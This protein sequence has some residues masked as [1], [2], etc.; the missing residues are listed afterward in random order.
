MAPESS[1]RNC[2]PGSQKSPLPAAVVNPPR[3]S[4]PR[5]QTGD[6]LQP[7]PPDFLRPVLPRAPG[8]F[9]L[10]TAAP[11]QGPGEP[12]LPR[13]PAEHAS[14]LTELPTATAHAPQPP[15]PNSPTTALVPPLPPRPETGSTLRT[16]PC[17]QL[18]RGPG[19]SSHGR[20]PP[21]PRAEA[22]TPRTREA[23]KPRGPASA[24]RE[25]GEVGRSFSGKDRGRFSNPRGHP[26]SLWSGEG[27]EPSRG[28]TTGRGSP[29]PDSAFLPL[30]ASSP[31]PDSPLRRSGW[32]GILGERR[33]HCCF[34]W[35][36]QR[37]ED[38]GAP[39]RGATREGGGGGKEET[40]SPPENS[41]GSD[42]RG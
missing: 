3:T 2:L 41:R 5:A 10:P 8:L 26:T 18:Q 16:P 19:G 13:S 21:R 20:S 38:P 17:S 24:P 30:S 35:A 12:W 29:H 37:T 25:R 15:P 6:Q 40:P 33:S 39:G 1:R 7:P 32:V 22:Q 14:P 36:A 42:P 4:G 34:G 27:A 23:A 31:S 11:R 9:A 28:A